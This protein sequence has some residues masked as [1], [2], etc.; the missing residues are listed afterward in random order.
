MYAPFLSKGEND[1]SFASGRGYVPGPKKLFLS[2][3]L[4]GEGKSGAE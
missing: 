4:E 1:F 2:V 3:V